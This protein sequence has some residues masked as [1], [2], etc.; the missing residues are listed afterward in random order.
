MT[1]ALPPGLLAASL[2]FWGWRIGLWLPALPMALLLELAP[3]VIWRWSLDDNALARVIDLSA[4][5]WVGALIILFTRYLNQ[6]PLATHLYTLL[7]WIPLLLFMPLVIQRYSTAGAFRVSHLFYSLRRSKSESARQALQLDAPYFVCCLLAAGV[8]AQPGFLPGIGLLL[9]WLLLAARPRRYRWP[10][11]LILAVVA[12][13]AAWP[14]SAGL[15]RFQ[16]AMEDTFTEWFE[17]WFIDVDPYR[18]RTALGDIGQLKLSGR[19]VLRLKPAPGDPGPWLLR[20]AA[21]NSYFDGVWQ[22]KNTRFTDLK[23]TGDG[24]EWPLSTMP[25]G[26]PRRLAISLELRWGTGMLPVPPGAWRLARLP[27][28]AV[29]ISSLG[30]IKASEGPGLLDYG[31][32][33]DPSADRDS[34]PAELDLVL[35]RRE[36]ATLQRL[37]AELDLI[38]QPPA[39]AAARVH[40]FLIGQFRYSLDLPAPATGLT[41]LET[42]LLQTRTG[43]CEYFASAAALLLRAAGIPARYAT[44]FSVSEYHA[45]EGVYVARRRHAHAWTLIWQDGRWQ[46]FDATPPDWTSF[47][48]EQASWWQSVGDL[49]AWLNHLFS[50]WRWR[51]TTGDEGDHRGW[52]GVVGGLTAVL[53]W[54]LLRRQRVRQRSAAKPM[55]ITIWPGAESPF[56]QILAALT[57][58]AGSRP[59]GESLERWLRQIGA[60]ETAEMNTMISQHQRWRFDPAGLSAVEQQQLAETVAVWLKAHAAQ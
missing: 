33:Y 49:W 24:R 50:R 35:P 59:P 14:L 48:D 56:H 28:G 41:A 8:T 13:L 52:W 6:P 55:A 42:F 30:A 60:G 43:H 51:E 38:N 47:E 27:V 7:S 36:Q 58:H 23:P 26:W 34:P 20:D 12:G 29:Q 21:Y 10:L 17:D 18:A 57:V 5:L 11:A 31:V 2:L 40:A 16:L 44:G 45:L 37:A 39:L 54:R 3:R 9:L 53:F 22:A 4:L 1:L 32:E 19:I 46:D 25:V 15:H